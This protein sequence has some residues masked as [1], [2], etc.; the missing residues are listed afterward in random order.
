MSID[1]PIV[2]YDNEDSNSHKK[3]E[4]DALADRWNEKRK[5]SPFR[6]GQKINLNDYL[7]NKI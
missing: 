6:K 3:R 4:M 2:V 5:N 1:T 7:Q